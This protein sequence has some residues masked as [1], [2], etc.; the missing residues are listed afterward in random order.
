MRITKE[1]EANIRAQFDA[2]EASKN[3]GVWFEVDYV[4]QSCILRIDGAEFNLTMAQGATLWDALK[5]NK[6]EK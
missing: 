5:R 1:Q 2:L 3:D 4:S 6:G